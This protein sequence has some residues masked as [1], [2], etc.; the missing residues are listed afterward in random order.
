MDLQA[1]LQVS[2]TMATD[3]VGIVESCTKLSLD[4]YIADIDEEEVT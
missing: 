1:A 3:G 4:F 2:S